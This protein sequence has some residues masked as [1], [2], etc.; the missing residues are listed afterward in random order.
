MEEAN[1]ALPQLIAK[2]NHKFSVSPAN[3]TSAHVPLS[4][5]MNHLQ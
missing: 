2:H 4:D 5:D 1:Q 3:D